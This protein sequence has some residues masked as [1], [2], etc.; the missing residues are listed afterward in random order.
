M[1]IT[2]RRVGAGALIIGGATRTINLAAAAVIFATIVGAAII[3]MLYRLRQSVAE[4][5]RIQGEQ[6]KKIS[7]IKAAV[8]I[9]DPPDEGK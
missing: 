5:E 6:A 4:L 3:V 2:A 1:W 8:G 7:Q 9:E